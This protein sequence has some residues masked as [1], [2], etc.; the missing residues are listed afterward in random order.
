MARTLSSIKDLEKTPY[1]DTH[2]KVLWPRNILP[3][4]GFPSPKHL[5]WGIH[6]NCVN[7]TGD[8]HRQSIP[9]GTPTAQSLWEAHMWTKMAALWINHG[10]PVFFLDKELTNLLERTDPPADLSPEDIELPF[11]AF[12]LILPDTQEFPLLLIGELDSHKVP[13]NSQAQKIL[14]DIPTV[15]GHPEQKSL[16]DFYS[17]RYKE[18]PDAHN[19]LTVFRGQTGPGKWQGSWCPLRSSTL[20]GLL[21]D[22]AAS[23]EKFYGPLGIRD[24][25][26]LKNIRLVLNFLCWLKYEYTPKKRPNPKALW[27]ENSPD[28]NPAMAKRGFKRPI[29]FEDNRPET[30]PK[31]KRDGKTTTH[32]SPEPH[33][34][35]GHWHTILFGEGKNQSEK[36]W[37]RPI[38]VSPEKDE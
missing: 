14:A 26:S 7:L 18:P 9:P 3:P 21:K 32:A 5:A 23:L 31:K 15:H 38:W 11:P 28:P 13:L 34:R 2:S 25:Q 19:H 24:D 22:Y 1:W 29:V 4:Q 17:L 6:C 16:L 20:Q 8:V 33:W 35:Q 27:G 10:N 12:G 30:P 37:F 36:R